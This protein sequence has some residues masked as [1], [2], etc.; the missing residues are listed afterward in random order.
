M[1]GFVIFAVI[2]IAVVAAADV[3]QH[4]QRRE[5]MREKFA[6]M[7]EEERQAMRQVHHQKIAEKL[8]KMTP[9]QQE[10][11]KNRVNRVMPDGARAFHETE[12]NTEQK[13][14]AF[15]ENLSGADKERAK[16]HFKSLTP[17][18]RAQFIERAKKFAGKAGKS[19]NVDG[20]I[21]NRRDRLPQRN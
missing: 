5:M 2:A 17:E 4:K 8:E 18:Q 11:L 7:P 21:P 1:K 3:E 13:I 10:K 15:Y 9:E 19:M 16:E 14:K 12:G 6:N 20:R